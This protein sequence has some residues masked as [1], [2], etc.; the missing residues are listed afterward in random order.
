MSLFELE[1]LVQRYRHRAA[2]C[3]VDALRVSALK[4]ERGEVLAVLGANGSGKTTLLETLAF[5]RRPSEG[6]LLLE[7]SD[8]WAV[9]GGLAARRRCPALLQKT[10][11]FSTSVLRNVTFGPRMLGLNPDLT[12]GRAREALA[13]VGLEGFED[14]RHDELSGGEARRVALARVLALEPEVMVLDEPTAGLDA[15][16][17]NRVESLI[18]RLNRERGTTVIL[19]SHSLK[20]AL[21]LATRVVT[22]VD[23][24]LV[25]GN[26]DNRTFGTTRRVA[27]GWEYQ[28]HRGWRY[29]YTDA[30]L[31]RDAWLGLGPIE[32]PV[33]LCVSS[34]AVRLA[35][36]GGDEPATLVGEVDAIRRDGDQARVRVRLPERQRVRARISL[37]ELER[38]SPRLGDRITMSFEPGSVFLFPGR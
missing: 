30:S 26:L 1:H 13:A 16:S 29:A 9:D 23:G 18:R 7:A 12:L 2:G 8:A 6:R 4:V 10:V 32:G 5:L 14:R 22:L 34:R 3:W 31:F 20:R 19:A 28:D 33:Q 24:C 38:L 21:T 35:P 36:P 11:L 25:D 27:G 17:S 15:E 37:A